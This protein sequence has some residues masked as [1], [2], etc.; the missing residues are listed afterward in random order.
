MQTPSKG[1]PLSYAKGMRALKLAE[2]ALV[3]LLVRS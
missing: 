2:D 3:F 1:L